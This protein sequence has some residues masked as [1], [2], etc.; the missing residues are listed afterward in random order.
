MSSESGSTTGSAAIT[1]EAATET[2][3]ATK[4]ALSYTPSALA[5]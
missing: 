4:A 5:S 3:R 2:I 1:N